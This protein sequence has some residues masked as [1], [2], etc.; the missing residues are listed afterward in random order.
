[1]PEDLRGQ[2]E[3]IREMVTPSISP[4]GGKYEADDAIG[5]WL[6]SGRGL[7]CQNYHRRSRP[8]ELVTNRVVVSLPNSKTNTVEDYFLR[9]S[10]KLGFCPQVVDYKAWSGMFL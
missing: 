3:R 6:A 10:S 7:G 1:M 8:V 5:T 2:V 9:T 4:A